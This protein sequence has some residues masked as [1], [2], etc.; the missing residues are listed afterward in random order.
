M[1]KNTPPHFMN[2][3]TLGRVLNLRKYPILNRLVDIMLIMLSVDIPRSVVFGKNVKLHHNCYG[4]VLNTTT[5]IEDNVQIFHGVTIGRGD[6]DHSRCA[7]DFDGFLIKEGAI[8]CAGCSIISSHGKL[9][10]GRGTIIGANSVLT[11]STGDYEVWVG[12]PA[13]KIKD[14]PQL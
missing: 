14:R 4:T 7:N 8:L 12:I 2:C 11:C 10:V 13:R 3:G 9:V 6:V 1:K 5:V